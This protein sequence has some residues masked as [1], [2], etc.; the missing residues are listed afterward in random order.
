MKTTTLALICLVLVTGCSPPR[1]AVDRRAY[2]ANR[3]LVKA[4]L[5]AARICPECVFRDTVVTVADTATAPL[6]FS[7]S[8]NVDSLLADC[9][10]LREAMAAEREL[11]LHVLAT[12]DRGQV[13]VEQLP[14]ATRKATTA[15]RARSCTFDTLVY[16]SSAVR[17]TV[18]PGPDAPLLS[19]VEKPQRIPCPPHVGKPVV[20]EKVVGVAPW[21]R[22]FTW[23]VLG[24]MILSF[25]FLLVV[26]LKQHYGWAIALL[27][28]LA[29]MAANAQDWTRTTADRAEGERRLVLSGTIAGA[30]SAYLQVYHD[31]DELY[32]NVIGRTWM[33]ELGAHAD[34]GLKF[35]DGQGRVK[36]IALHELSDDMVEFYPPIEVDFDRVG[37]LVLIKQ[38]TGKPDWQEFD[39]GMSKKVK[40]K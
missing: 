31:G 17:V 30:D 19:V 24:I 29:P 5:K 1:K 11:Y 4:E 37:N 16:E 21:Y 35:T 3:V 14:P 27:L 18:R 22:V 2:R 25:L 8:M 26:S 40:V 12:G 38:S 20:V 7:D 9:E 10:Q 23:I 34:Y 33:L 28:S 36:R 13:K 39:V 6:L 15:I 32:E